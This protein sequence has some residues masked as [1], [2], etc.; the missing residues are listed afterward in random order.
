MTISF[1]F[2]LLA[3][4][5]LWVQLQSTTAFQPLEKTPVV[6]CPGFGNDQ[7]DYYEPLQ[8]PREVGLVSALERRGFDPDL[9][10]TIPVQRSDWIRVAGG[11]LDWKF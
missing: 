7:I 11:L 2:S 1:R 4:S 5:V 10:F 3:C 8:Q 6:I 9:I